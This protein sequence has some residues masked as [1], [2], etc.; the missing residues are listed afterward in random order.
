MI[1]TM[2][3]TCLQ[4]CRRALLAA[5]C[6]CLLA[7]C[8]ADWNNHYGRDESLPTA[9]LAQQI[10]AEE[11]LSVFMRMLEITGMD[12]VLSS[13]Q[14]YTVWAP[15]DAALE[16][17]D[18]NDV[19][20][21]RRVLRNHVARYASPSSTDASQKIY[22]LNGKPMHFAEGRFS[23]I[24]LL[25]SDVPC[26]NG[27][28]HKMADQIPYKYNILE[29]ISLHP[30]YSDLY[31]FICR[32]DEKI[33]DAALS[34]TYDS[35]FVNY[36]P[37]LQDL[38]YGIGAIGNEDSTYTMILP[39]NAAWQAAYERISPYFRPFNKEQALADSIQKVQTSL[40]IVAGL[41]FRQVIVSPSAGDSLLTVTQKLIQGAG[42]YLNGYQTVEASN[43]MIYLAKGHLNAN[44]SCVWNHVINLE[45]EN[46]DY[47]QSLSGTNAYI[48]TTDMN[49]LVQHVSDAAYLEA[50]SGNVDGGIVFDIPNTLAATYDVYVDFVSP[51]VDGENMREEKTKVVFQLK[52]MGDNGR[53][54]IKNNNT[55]TEVAVPEKGGIVSVKAFSAVPFPVADFYDNMWKLDKDNVGADMAETTTLQVKTKVSSTDAKKGY[56]RKCRIDR[57]RLVPSVK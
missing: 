39:D 40:A 12:S 53:L 41:T 17:L 9:T 49:S 37:L 25:K 32:F 28:L 11:D 18:M 27:I 5:I 1:K 13:S 57:I 50:S 24:E 3:D 10:D 29:Y 19:E 7:S 38:K 4:C 54:T 15:V 20:S 43:G 23:G 30:E 6:V 48:R 45:A 21:L 47:R 46:M 51:L 35:V 52:F 44:D 56:V 34:S 26:K 55:A 22:M 8:T 33:Y 2:K 16:G 36:N 31:D 42:D 14:T